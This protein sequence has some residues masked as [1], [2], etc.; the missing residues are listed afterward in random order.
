MLSIETQSESRFFNAKKKFNYFVGL[1][2]KE[3]GE[4]KRSY[5][6]YAWIS[7]QYY[8]FAELLALAGFYGK[9][10]GFFYIMAADFTKKRRVKKKI[11]FLII[12]IFN[13]IFNY[14]I[15]NYLIFNYFY[16]TFNFIF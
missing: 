12:F 3:V 7:R 15:F 13:F 5:E 8:L 4:L 11:I 9:E 16:F 2:K 10:V 14:L 1:F 6:H